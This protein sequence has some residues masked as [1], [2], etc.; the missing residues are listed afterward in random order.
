MSRWTLLSLLLAISVPLLVN[1]ATAE[2]EGAVGGPQ[3]ISSFVQQFCIDCHSS[4]DPVAGLD[5]DNLSLDLESQSVLNTWVHVYDRIVAGEMPPM[6]AGQP[7]RQSS[8]E[9]LIALAGTITNHQIE[10][11][12]VSGRT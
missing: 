10:E 11:E 1:V 12:T 6:E 5:L 3:A 2:D 7:D 4:D 8:E 9:F